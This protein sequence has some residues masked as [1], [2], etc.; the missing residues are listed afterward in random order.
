MTPRLGRG[1]LLEAC[2][3]YWSSLEWSETKAC[4]GVREGEGLSD[5]REC[6]EEAKKDSDP[7]S[8]P[9]F[10]VILCHFIYCLQESTKTA[11]IYG[12]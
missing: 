10:D 9:P 6:R 5:L 4:Q 1:A 11:L 2:S 8:F 12:S 3:G 7:V